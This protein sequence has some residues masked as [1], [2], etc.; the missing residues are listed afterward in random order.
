MQGYEWKRAAGVLMSISSLPSPYGIGTLGKA[1]YNFADWLKKAGQA[2]W[3]VL[4]VG[5]TGLGDSPYQSFSA[6]AGNPYFIDL[7][8]LIKE[9]LLKRK[10]VKDI[11]WGIREEETDY[12]LIYMNRFKVLRKAY[13]AS[14]H[15]NESSYVKFCK[16][17]AFWLDDYAL[18]MALKEHFDNKSWLD[19]DKDIRFR[20]ETALK[21]YT[22]ELKEDIDYWKFCQFKF[23]EQWNS[24]KEYVNNLG[25]KII[26]DIPLY[27]SLDSADVWADNHLFKMNEERRPTHV[28]GVPPDCFSE[29]GQLWGNPI[30]DWDTMAAEDYRWWRRRIEACER[31]YDIIRI[32]HFIGIVRYYEIRAG[33]KNAK[34][35]RWRKGPGAELTN[36][37]QEIS[38]DSGII[39][40]D[41]GVIVPKV[42]KLIDRMG[43]PGMK[44]LGF[45]FD[46]NAD[47]EYLPHN[48]RDSNYVLY[49]GT[50]DNDTLRGFVDKLSK[51]ELKQIYDYLNVDSIED[52]PKA[53]IRCGYASTASTA[54]FQMQDI[55]GLG[56]EARM[57]EPATVG[58]NWRWR[59]TKE[60]F[61]TA[62]AAYLKKLAE[63]YGRLI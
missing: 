27:M 26:G 46:G 25:I 10:D 8:I 60:Q 20:E 36:L 51:K 21:K 56:A 29:D 57:N 58:R 2:Y 5:P 43:W 24:L 23:Y 19:W 44:I 48:Y 53:M 9:G 52:I 41:L 7:D 32:D 17:Q 54:I 12:G 18:Y 59:L 63:V 16:E 45:A 47:N 31:L 30:Y 13:S 35:G 39:A 34:I 15:R 61:R 22:E 40:E 55:L 1:A 42:R 3:Q 38:K 4:P 37:I 49:G 62:D 11:K 14:N 6:F 28:A 33:R 50:H